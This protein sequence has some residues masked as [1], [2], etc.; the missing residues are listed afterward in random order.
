MLYFFRISVKTHMKTF[1]HFW[2][3]INLK[4]C[5]HFNREYTGFV[6]RIAILYR[7]VVVVL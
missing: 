7:L 2:G 1:L 3:F 5:F 6:K 4:N